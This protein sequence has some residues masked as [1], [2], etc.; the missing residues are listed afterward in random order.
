MTRPLPAAVLAAAGLVCL[1]SARVAAAVVVLANATADPVRVTVTHPGRQP[2]A[3]QLASAD[4]L[5]VTCGRYTDVAFD[6]AGKPARLRLDAYSAY[7]FVSRKGV[8]DLYGIELAGKPVPLDDVP[9]EPPAPAEPLKVSVKLLADDADRRTRAAWERVVRARFGEAARVVAAHCPVKFEVVEADEWTSDP[10]AMLL[11]GLYAEFQK[12]VTPAPARLAV[13]VTSR[14]PR[15]AGAGGFG[16]AGKAAFSPHILV[17]EGEPRTEAERVEVLIQQLGKYLGAVHCAD[18]GSAMRPKLGDGKATIARF[19]L[20]FDPLNTLVMNIWV[21]EAR[22]VKAE[23]LA[24]LRPAAQARLGRIY[25]TLA[26][27]LPEEQLPA[28]YTAAV[29]KAEGRGEEGAG[30]PRVAVAPRFEDPPPGRVEI[31]P[32][33]G[34]DEKP[35]AQDQPAAAPARSEKTL[36]P[37]QEAARKVVRA[38]VQRAEQNAAAATRL[39]GDALTEL[40]IRTAADIA[41]FE[42]KEIRPAAF[43]LGLGIALDDSEVLRKNPLSDSFCHAVESDEERKARLVVI[44]LP[45]VRNRRDLC[46]HFVVSA[47]LTELVGGVLAEQAGLLKEKL[48][49]TRA[50]G[51]SFTDLCADLAGVAFAR[52]TKKDPDL[53]E[54]WW[55]DF[56]LADYVPKMDGLRDGLTEERFKQDYGSFA[57]DRFKQA[58]DDIRTRV[59][60]QRFYGSLDK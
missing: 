5:P 47:A 49:M 9:V 11:S 24:G 37:K 57:D 55:Q 45:T 20:G 3:Y 18:P 21:E 41:R 16:V 43:L 48:D 26:N 33:P 12:S 17:R 44:G 25:A 19:R 15:G 10:S 36:T 14:L 34:R 1:T 53:L 58:L 23:K 40:Y 54:Q 28:D 46:Q 51:F 60:K 31:R 6:R 29:A 32:L 50:S 35:P 4:V 39:R 59:R 22:A 38:I 8:T 30:E 2:V 7:V 13:G 27:A 42:D 56:K 52:F